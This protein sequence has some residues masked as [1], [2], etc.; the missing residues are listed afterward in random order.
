MGLM[1]IGEYKHSLDE[2]GRVALPAKFRFS[3]QKGLVITRGL[4]DKCLFVYPMDEWEKLASKL[5]SM[6]IAQAN[7]LAFTRLML[8]GA[9]DVG[10]D[11]QGRMLLPD[12]LRKYAELKKDVVIAGLYNRLE[13]WDQEA[14]EAYRANA[15]KN[16]SEIAEKLESLGI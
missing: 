15:E 16:S 11:S 1:F 14:W 12:Y 3:M 10:L 2:K 5:S 6:P 7:S 8:A 4:L 13:I 9:M